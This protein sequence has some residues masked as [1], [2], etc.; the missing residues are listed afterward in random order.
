MY[1]KR[2]C[3]DLLPSNNGFTAHLVKLCALPKTQ[4][5]VSATGNTSQRDS[6]RLLYRL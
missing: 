5:V 3:H 1:D 2:V 6:R 4:S